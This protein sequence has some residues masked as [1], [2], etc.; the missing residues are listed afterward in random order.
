LY[1]VKGGVGGGSNLK[2]V[3]QVLAGIQI[4]AVSEAMGLASWLGLDRK[5]VRD[6]VIKSG[7]WSWM[8]ENRSERMLDEDYFPGVSALTIILKDVVR[9]YF[10]SRSQLANILQGIITS[11]ARAQS[12]PAPLSSTAEQVYLSALAKGYGKD[13]DAGVVRF[14][15]SD[16]PK[17]SIGDLSPENI[18]ARIDLVVNL[19]KGI[20]VCAAAEAIAFTKNLGLDLEQFYQLTKDAAGGSREFQGPGWEMIQL[21]EGRSNSE[22]GVSSLI[23][24]HVDNLKEVT[25]EARRLNCPLYLGN[26][27]LN[28]CL[29]AVQK[30]RE[31]RVSA[32]PGLWL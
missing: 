14:Y 2:M 8:F 9:F 17:V 1:I 11:T 7:G 16:R 18:A 23:T 24:T 28:L 27:A 22:D 26:Q 4:L 5:A 29:I 3:H 19:L 12:F 21:I 10:S 6:E 32:L 30:S 20:H 31:T 13:D 25:T 15:Y